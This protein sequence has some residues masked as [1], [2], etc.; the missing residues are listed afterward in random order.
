[1]Q[2]KHILVLYSNKNVKGRKDGRYF[3]KL[4]REFAKHHEVPSENMLGI[5]CPGVPAKSRYRK[6][7][8]FISS[9]RNIKD[10]PSIKWVVMFCHGYSSGMQFGLSKKNIH[11][12]VSHLKF[13]CTKNLKMTLY[14]CSTASTSK[15]TRKISM[16]GTDNGYADKLRDEMLK[17]GFHG[18]W[19]DAHLTP[20][21]TV[22]NPF[23][24]R[25]YTEPRFENDWDMPGG[26]WLVSPKSQLWHKWKRSVQNQISA[27]RF[28]YTLYTEAE[29][30]E[31]L[32]GVR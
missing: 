26:E 25:F 24:L 3:T 8:R 15:K 1:M 16:P 28:R 14:A 23:V 6:A 30:Y 9:K 21:D 17:Q 7:S 32:K 11:G 4:A 19:I 10:T 13:S 31:F 27:F 5:E 2:G 29:I 20:G 12:F 22:Y 18:G